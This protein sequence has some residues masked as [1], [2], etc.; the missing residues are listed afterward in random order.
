MNAEVQAMYLNLLAQMAL[1]GMATFAI[2][3]PT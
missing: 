3:V 1:T 2:L